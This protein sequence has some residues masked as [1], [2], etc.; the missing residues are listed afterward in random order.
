MSL[1]KFAK[2]N[3][4]IRR[5][6][7]INSFDGALTILGIILVSWFAGVVDAKHIILPSVGAAI[8]M[9]VSGAW[10]AYASESAEQKSQLKELEKHLLNKL[11]N[12]KIEYRGKKIAIIVG[13]VDGLSPLIASFMIIIPFFMANI[14]MIG[15]SYAYIFSIVVIAFLLFFLGTLSGHISKENRF[16]NGMKML[17]AGLIIGVIFYAMMIFGLLSGV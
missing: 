13:L 16:I 10:G 3:E 4:I 8:A 17:V 2:G 12:T 15:I 14:G 7:I 1:W 6:F 5:Y 11:E 9:F